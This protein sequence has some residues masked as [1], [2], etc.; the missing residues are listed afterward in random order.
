LE[1]LDEKMKFES[2]DALK[3]DFTQ[4]YK[5]LIGPISPRPIA[6]VSTRNLDGSNNLAPFSFFT[7]V[8]AKPMIIAFCP[9][10]RSSNEAKKDT[11]V[12]IE[13]EKEFVINFV[14]EAIA[15]KVNLASS[16]LPYGEDEFK[17]AGFTPL[18]SETIKAMRV[19]ESMVH[20]ECKLRDILSY[21][22]KKGAGSLITGEVVKIHVESSIYVD[23]KI[24][25]HKYRP[26]A[27]GAGN[28]WVRY[29]DVFEMERL[30]K[31]QIQ[32]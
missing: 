5:F 30:M 20:F 4:N 27:R 13:R 12:N 2:L 15:S 24:D 18:K 19:Q 17:F 26:V 8:S 3:Q 11:Q 16:E 21:G 23:G 22:D 1:K 14:H 31:M 28:D 10:I 32:K 25:M 7:A 6:F 29:T 9:M